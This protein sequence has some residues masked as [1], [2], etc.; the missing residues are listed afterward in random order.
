MS[1]A[2]YKEAYKRQIHYIFNI[3]YEWAI[4]HWDGNSVGGE[5]V[6]KNGQEDCHMRFEANLVDGKWVLDELSRQYID[7]T[8]AAAIEAYFNEHG[9][10]CP[11]ENY[12]GV[13]DGR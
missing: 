1:D 4:T 8:T 3:Q 5:E 11:G 12:D 9:M 13:N 10:P 6:R 7:F 2:E